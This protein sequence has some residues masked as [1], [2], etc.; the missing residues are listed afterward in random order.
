VTFELHDMLGDDNWAVVDWAD[1][2]EVHDKVI[3]QNVDTCFHVLL[4][5][6]GAT[7]LLGFTRS[8]STSLIVPPP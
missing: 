2:P 3:F 7:T 1:A 5:G 8:P 6:G 4:A